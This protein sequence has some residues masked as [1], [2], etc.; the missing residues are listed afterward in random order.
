MLFGQKEKTTIDVDE[1]NAR[2]LKPE[3]GQLSQSLREIGVLDATQL[4]GTF[5]GMNSDLQPW[6]TGERLTDLLICS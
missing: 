2:L 5:A 1:W 4:L 6:F 3:Y